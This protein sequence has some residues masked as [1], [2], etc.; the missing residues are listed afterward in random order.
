MKPA[1]VRL[2]G[3]KLTQNPPNDR[4]LL[5]TALLE[6]VNIDT[7]L[8]IIFQSLSL[9]E[10]AEYRKYAEK[11]FTSAIV[12]GSDRYAVYIDQAKGKYSASGLLSDSL[13]AKLDVYAECIVLVMNYI[14]ESTEEGTND[15]LFYCFMEIFEECIFG[16]SFV[17][18][19]HH[20]IYTLAVSTEARKNDFMS[21]L[22]SIAHSTDQRREI[23]SV[24]M[25]SFV[26]GLDY[27][28][29][30]SAGIVNEYVS[31]CID[32][33]KSMDDRFSGVLLGGLLRMSENKNHLVD[34]SI[35]QVKGHKVSP[36]YDRE[37]LFRKTH[38][39]SYNRFIDETQ[40]ELVNRYRT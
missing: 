19:V 25:A 17:Y 36:I 39:K 12:N 8:G 22:S 7:S 11:A 18:G 9:E 3:L 33:I 16:L 28:S 14:R 20:V 30:E 35:S 26:S 37:C 4:I 15:I 23:A 21:F 34:F 1:T 31:C 38:I 2:K 40:E 32:R 5:R 6:A 24:Y 27:L 10:H 29:D 13:Y